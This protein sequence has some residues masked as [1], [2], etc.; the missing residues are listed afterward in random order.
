[1]STKN[2]ATTSEEWYFITITTVGW[3]VV[4]TRLNQKYVIIN[5][6]KHSQE[7]EGLEINACILMCSHLHLLCKA[8]EGFILSDLIRDLKNLLQKNNTNNYCRT[9][10]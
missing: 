9:L 7:H 2:K 6:L 5:S 4:F 10:K 1:M 8:T 3:I